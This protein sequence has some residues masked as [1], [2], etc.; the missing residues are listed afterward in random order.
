M[1]VKGKELKTNK[2]DVP[3]FI[4]DGKEYKI[5]MDFNVLSELEEIYGNIDKAFDDIQ[6]L[7]IKALRAVIYSIVKAENENV[8]LKEIGKKLDIDFI[9]NFVEKMGI[10][11]NDSMPEKKD[12]MGE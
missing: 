6:A 12:N 11:L 3:T 2:K 8:T 5:V 10:V 1:A 7:K 9:E 4:L